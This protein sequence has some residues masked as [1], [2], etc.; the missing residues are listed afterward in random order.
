MKDFNRIRMVFKSVIDL[1]FQEYLFLGN[2]KESKFIIFYV[3][4]AYV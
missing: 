3:Y 1:Y 4:F 2:L